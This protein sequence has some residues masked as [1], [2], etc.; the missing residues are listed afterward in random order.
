MVKAPLALES[1]GKNPTD[2][3]KNGDK[4][5]CTDGWN[6]SSFGSGSFWSQ[7]ARCQTVKSVFGCYLYWQQ[8]KGAVMWLHASYSA[9]WRG[10]E[11]VG[12]QSG[13]PS[14]PLGCWGHTLFLIVFVKCW[15]AMRRKPPIISLL[16]SLLVPLL[17]G[18]N[19]YASIANRRN[20]SFRLYKWANL[21][22]AQI[23]PHTGN[24][25]AK[26]S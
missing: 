26:I 24:I 5:Q 7:Y 18:V 21:K 6:Q 22:V 2:R 8:W 19:S 13:L 10:K 25:F 20:S 12:T 9:P 16:F 23:C 14:P 17:S 1:V 3:G 15:S 4:T 11:G